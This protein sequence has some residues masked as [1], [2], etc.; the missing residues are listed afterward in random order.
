MAAT[1]PSDFRQLLDE[2]EPATLLAL[3]E[4]G[5]ELPGSEDVEVA[6]HHAGFAIESLID[7]EPP[8]DDVRW[9]SEFEVSLE[10]FEHTFVGRAALERSNEGLLVD[11]I[12]WRH[13]H[14]EDM[15]RAHDSEWTVSLSLTLGESPLTNYHRQLQVLDALTAAPALAY[16]ADAATPRPAGWLLQAAR[17]QTPPNPAN[18]FTI[19]A[20][21]GEGGDVWLHTHGLV[22]CGSLE[23]DM[24]DIPEAGANVCGELLNQVAA[25][26]IEQGVPEPGEP[27]LAGQGIELVWLPWDAA[28]DHIPKTALGGLEDRTDDVHTGPRAVLFAPGKGLLGRRKYRSVAGYI[29]TL[30]DNPLLYISQMETQRMTLLASEMLP[31]FLQL[32]SQHSSLE[33]WLFLVKLGYETNHASSEREHLWFQVHAQR[34]G[35]VDATLLNEPYGV[36]SMHEGERRRHSLDRL[37][38]WAIL[39][40]HGR[41][42]ADTIGALERLLRDQRN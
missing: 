3:L 24:V 10:G 11:E 21:A 1:F 12:A 8:S 15:Q 25:L 13:V 5:S 19:H 4:Q 20:V 18:L 36:G 40:P 29:S 30:E 14:P 41:F 34:G 37:T 35:E 31:R 22:R 7:L 26:F 17:A 2:G 42:N 6:L 39:C 32:M 38:D 9:A 16:D 33:D 27:F 28:L 23:L